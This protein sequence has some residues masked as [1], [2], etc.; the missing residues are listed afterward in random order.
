M[1]PSRKK[2]TKTVFQL[3]PIAPDFRSEKP[4]VVKTLAKV[5]PSQPKKKK[6]RSRGFKYFWEAK[7]TEFQLRYPQEI[8]ARLSKKQKRQIRNELNLDELSYQILC[9]YINRCK[10]GTRL[11]KQRKSPKNKRKRKSKYDTYIN[12]P[13]WTERKNKYYQI[14]RR[15]CAACGSFNHIHLHH[16][17]YEKYGEEPDEHLIPLCDNHHKDYHSKNGTQRHMI[18]RTMAYVATI[19]HETGHNYVTTGAQEHLSD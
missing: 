3:L 12:S 17:V 16:M 1:K 9:T 10:R 6:K 11:H 14:H 4:H 15:Q 5:T 19:N 18:E 13:L 7:Q 8:A 2:K